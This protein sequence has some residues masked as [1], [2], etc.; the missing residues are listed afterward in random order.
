MFLMSSH[1]GTVVSVSGDNN[2]YHAYPEEVYPDLCFDIDGHII[3]APE[4][5]SKLHDIE[6]R[7][8]GDSWV[9]VSNGQF[10]CADIAVQS[11]GE[12]I[13]LPWKN[14]HLCPLKTT[15]PFRK[16]ASGYPA[17]DRQII[18][19]GPCTRF[20]SM[21]SYHPRLKPLRNSFVK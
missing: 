9:I 15:S 16:A 12:Q 3:R 10:M 19:A 2:F 6:T 8:E 17:R 5:F 14:S 20:F 4:G 7:R 18:S 13:A 21:V 11:V 1:F